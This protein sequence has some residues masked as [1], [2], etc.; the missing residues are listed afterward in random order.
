MAKTIHVQ[1]RAHDLWVRAAAK[2]RLSE[3]W[4]RDAASVRRAAAKV[5]RRTRRAKVAVSRSWRR[6]KPK[7]VRIEHKLHDGL[8]SR[9]RRVAR[10]RA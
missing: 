5:E 6:V 3:Q 10:M 9:W 1:E 7:V 2:V 8:L 4:D